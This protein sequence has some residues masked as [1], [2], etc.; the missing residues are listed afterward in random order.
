MKNVKQQVV[1]WSTYFLFAILVVGFSACSDDDTETPEVVSE[2][3]RTFAI[4]SA[5]SNRAEIELGELAATRATNE[6]VRSF[7]QL[8]VE[9]HTTAQSKLADI[10][11]DLEIAVP[12]TLDAAHQA[13]HAQLSTLSGYQFDSAYIRSQVMDHELAQEL[14]ETQIQEGEN[15]RLVKYAH[16]TFPIINQHLD[17]ILGLQDELI[18][19]GDGNDDGTTG[20]NE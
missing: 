16:Q 13:I 9:N 11:S 15:E 17:E 20:G 10:A 18:E 19:E 12:D 7:A 6:S 14:M 1:K 4:N 2:Q 5:Y 8:M 3:D